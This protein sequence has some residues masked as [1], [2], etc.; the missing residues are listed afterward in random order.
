[1]QTMHSAFVKTVCVVSTL[2]QVRQDGHCSLGR[3]RQATNPQALQRCAVVTCKCGVAHSGRVQ[4]YAYGST[5][6]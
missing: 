3:Q 5:S 1:M 2:L 4:R 6:S